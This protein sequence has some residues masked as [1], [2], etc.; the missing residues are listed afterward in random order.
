MR[1]AIDA[2]VLWSLINREADAPGWKAALERAAR[3]GDLVISPVAFAEIAPAYSSEADLVE[4][5]DRLTISFDPLLAA[6]A[7]KAGQIFKAYRKAGGPR[8]TM[9]PDFLIAAHAQEQADRLAAADR[10]YLRSYFPTLKLLTP[11]G[12]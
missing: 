2:S 7:W 12:D 6:A 5:L 11:K 9:V 8:S 3:D 1:T 4:D 10:G